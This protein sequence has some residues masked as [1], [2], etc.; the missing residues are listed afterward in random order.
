MGAPETP[1]VRDEATLP[2]RRFRGYTPFGK[3]PRPRRQCVGESGVGALVT[4]GA[5]VVGERVALLV[6]YALTGVSQA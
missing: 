1:P 5:G 6:P 3:A 4:K 2:P